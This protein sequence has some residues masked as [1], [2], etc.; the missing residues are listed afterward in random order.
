MIPTL[1]DRIEYVMTTTAPTW[2]KLGSLTEAISCVETS[3]INAEWEMVLEYPMNGHNAS[4]I[5]IMRIIWT[6]QPFYIYRIA[7]NAASHIMTVYCRHINYLLSFVPAWPFNNGTCAPADFLTDSNPLGHIFNITSE[8]TAT[9]NVQLLDNNVV[10]SDLRDLMLNEQ[11]GM[12]QCY[13]GEWVFDGLDCTLKTRK[14]ATKD[15]VIRYGVD[16]VDAKQDEAIDNIV[17]HIIPYV[18]MSDTLNGVKRACNYINYQKQ[19]K[20]STSSGKGTTYSIGLRYEYHTDSISVTPHAYVR[21][22]QADSTDK[23]G[24]KGDVY[25]AGESDVYA[26]PGANSFPFK[27]V[28]FVNILDYAVSEGR[29]LISIYGSEKLESNRVSFLEG[30]IYTS[31]STGATTDNRRTSSATDYTY[32]GVGY[33]FYIYHNN[34]RAAAQSYVDS[35]PV[36]FPVDITVQ[37]IPEF[38]EGVKLGDTITVKFEDYGIDTQAEIMTMEYDVLREQIKSYTLGEGRTSFVQTMLQQSQGLNR[39]NGLVSANNQLKGVG[40]EE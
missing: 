20:Y 7:K 2:T 11:Y 24:Y 21:T 33:G 8:L 30:S 37:S 3:S 22:N 39:L 34:L 1:Y 31:D 23:I 5:Q 35:H 16:L 10:P 18:Y 29:K 15:I 38:M 4:A 25:F 26:L 17:T 12:A 19:E 36:Q 14:G 9:K 27:R 28:K 32:S 13:G 40:E 6:T